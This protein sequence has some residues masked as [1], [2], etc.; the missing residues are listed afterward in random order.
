MAELAFLAAV[1]EFLAATPLVPA[2]AANRIGTLEPMAPGD[3]PSIVLSLDSTE[4]KRVGLGERSELMTGALPV[5]SSIDLANPFLP[6]DPDFSLIDATRRIV[7]LPHGGLVR[8][9]GAEAT[10]PLAPEDIS[11][12]VDGTAVTVVT[13]TPNAGEVHADPIEGTLRFGTALGAAGTL[14]IEYFLGQWERR[15]ERIA[16]VLRVDTCAASAADASQL[17]DSTVTRLLSSDAIASI[18]KLITISLTSL[19]SVDRR[20]PPAPPENVGV[21][22]FRRRALCAFEFQHIV[23]RADSSGGVIRGIPL[24]SRLE[25]SRLDRR[26]NT[27]ITDLVVETT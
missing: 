25:A 11:V 16:G 21:A 7:I 13:G 2:V 18:V 12:R 27:I 6:D 5:H 22:H 20:S 15:V 26:T 17:G 3:L 23:D 19:S 9:D 8:T 4:R 1:R 14:A 24:V 10:T